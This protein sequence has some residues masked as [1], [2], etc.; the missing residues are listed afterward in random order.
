[1]TQPNY[2][3]QPAPAPV[4]TNVKPSGSLGWAI[5]VAI[6]GILVFA[7]PAVFYVIIMAWGSSMGATYTDGAGLLY[8]LQVLTAIVGGIVGTALLSVSI[9]LRHKVLAVCGAF[10]TLLALIFGWGYILF[11]WLPVR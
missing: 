10:A 9:H 11:I 3:L 7:P 2:P 6:V 8:L 4:T 5:A 1:M